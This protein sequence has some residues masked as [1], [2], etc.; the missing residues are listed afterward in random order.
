MRLQNI[1]LCWL[2]SLSQIFWLPVSWL[3][4]Q[5]ILLAL[6]VT[7]VFSALWL[8]RNRRY[9]TLLLLFAVTLCSAAYQQ[10]YIASTLAKAERIAEL[11]RQMQTIDAEFK[12]VSL[13]QMLV[14][15]TLVAE[16]DLN[17]YQLD[18]IK[19]NIHWQAEA[20]PHLGEIWRATLKLRPLSS[21]LNE[22][23][24]N[25]Q[26]WL[27]SQ[28]ILAS[29]TMKQGELQQR[30][31]GWRQQKLEQIVAQT[32][33]FRY[34]GVILAL[35]FG[36]R[37][38]ITAHD[39]QRFRE[40]GTAH[41]IAISGLHIGLVAT[42]AW[43]MARLAQLLLIRRYAALISYPLP[44]LTALVAAAFYAY[45][46][47][48]LIP[49]Q[50]ALWAYC[51]WLGLSFMRIYLP[52]WKLLIL[53]IA[54]LSLL[55][56]LSLLNE[57]FWLSCGTVAILCF[58]YHYF[59]LSGLRWRGKTLRQQLPKIGYWILGLLH[60]QL[61]LLLLFTPLQL[62]VFKALPLNAFLSN[63]LL[64]P[65]FS[66]VLVP[67]ILI[68][69]FSGGFSWHWVDGL[70]QRT[71]ALL[72]WL[73]NRY[74]PVSDLE[75]DGMILLV[76]LLLGI[77][78]GLRR[79]YRTLAID[80]TT[81]AKSAVKA[82][83]KAAFVIGILFLLYGGK[84]VF[85]QSRQADWQL[86]MLDVGQ[87]LAL[88]IVERQHATLFDTG[89]AWQGG[90]MAE[91]EILPYLQRNGL[92]LEQLILSHDDNDHA[93]GAEVLLRHFPSAVLFGSSQKAYNAQPKQACIQGARWLW[94]GF[95]FEVFA[96]SQ[97]VPVAKNQDSCVVLVSRDNVRFILSGDVART[98]EDRIAQH[99]GKVDWLQVGHH[100][101]NTSSGWIWLSR[102]RPTI[103][104]ISAGL[105]NQWKLPHTATLQRLRHTQSAVYN[106][107]L[108]GQITLSVRAQ[109]WQ[110]ST[111]RGG[112]LAW[113][114]IIIG[115][116]KEIQLE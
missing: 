21:R 73:P 1:A 109:N 27:L 12:I 17:G 95:Q 101:S 76:L 26:R 39:W 82:E 85:E 61:G 6:A 102:L 3:G 112:W 18:K 69:L 53:I 86:V 36:E 48:F 64:V 74:W 90:S 4:Y 14:N 116:E 55:D 108:D 114:Q 35:A 68:S 16:L 79:H 63:L 45:L 49:T 60:L 46:A 25:R 107:A 81:T 2:L 84:V 100:G 23:G 52:P 89:Q 13:R 93:G 20:E 71:L 40:S 115:L 51:F 105:H 72:D 42:M 96:P 19:V 94:R 70:L 103:S 11:S 24:F 47:D 58:Y 78:F 28:S 62:F 113:Y 38:W 5:R 9:R 67:L 66:L 15:R 88:L 111:A 106:T 59:P 29:A 97:W 30:Q 33:G 56:P 104:L 87:G 57:S 10:W 31:N 32:D 98:T 91:T 54:W 65:L 22:G 80:G 41:L 37:A 110:I 34:Q 92:Q 7:A 77:L 99:I 83:N 50:R 44:H 8:A 75:R 43:G